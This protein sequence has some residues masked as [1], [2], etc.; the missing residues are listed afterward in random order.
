MGHPAGVG[1]S[2]ARRCRCVHR[3]TGATSTPTARSSTRAAWC[4]PG[5]RP[6][7]ASRRPRRSAS[8]WA[9]IFPWHSGPRRTAR[10]SRRIRP[11]PT[12]P[13]GRVN[14]RVVGIG[15]FADEVLPEGLYPRRRVLVPDDVT[16]PFNCTPSLRGLGD[17]ASATVISD[18]LAPPDC[19]LAFQYFSL[20]LRDGERGLGPVLANLAE[21]FEVETAQL[22]ASARRVRVALPAHSRHRGDER[23]RVERSLDPA[24][25]ALRIFALI[26]GSA[27]F[28]LCGFIVTRIARRAR[29]DGEIWSQLGATRGQRA[30][31]IAVG[32]LLATVLGG[33]GALGVGRVAA[34]LGPVASAKALAPSGAGAVPIGELLAAG[35]HRGW[36]DTDRD[37]GG[38]AAGVPLAHGTSHVRRSRQPLADA[39]MRSGHLPFAFGFRAATTGLAAALGLDRGGDRCCDRS[40]RDSDLQCEPLPDHR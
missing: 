7:S 37:H 1:S 33:L 17:N 21:R 23:V 2:T 30:I 27:T 40:G 15:V 13:L 16:A 26:A 32:P 25:N 10:P 31:A 8:R 38:V 22:P 35:R 34:D 5:P 3:T 28:V 19:T 4:S 36:P 18:A 9:T 24:V 20:H 12:E 39:A 14:V 6:S 29:T 11:R